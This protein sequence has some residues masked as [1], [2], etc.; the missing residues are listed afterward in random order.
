MTH[1]KLLNNSSMNTLLM[2]CI[3]AEDGHYYNRKSYI[4]YM[5]YLENKDKPKVKS[6]NPKKKKAV[7]MPIPKAPIPID[8]KVHE[9]FKAAINKLKNK[10]NMPETDFIILKYRT[11]VDN[12]NIQTIVMRHPCEEFDKEYALSVLYER[13]KEFIK[14]F[15]ANEN[16]KKNKLEKML[17]RNIFAIVEED[18]AILDEDSE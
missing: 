8:D 14:H 10:Y 17:K 13:M 15:E 7:E 12:K 16:G 2:Y 5:N 18:I 1:K 6:T 3:F 9:K 11:G 4:T